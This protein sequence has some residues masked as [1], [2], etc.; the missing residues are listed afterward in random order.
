MR[1]LALALAGMLLTTGFAVAGGEGADERGE[2]GK[3]RDRGEAEE[4]GHG[5]HFA[6]HPDKWVLQNDDITVWFHQGERSKPVLKVF[7]STEDGN[8]SGFKLQLDELFEAR[9]V[10]PKA[11]DA[12]DTDD[13]GD[14][15]DG[16]EFRRVRGHRINLHPARE[17][18]TGVSNATDEVT[19]TMSHLFN[20]G[21]VTLVFHVPKNGSTVKF[22]VLVEDWKWADANNTLALRLKVLERGAEQEG[23]NATFSGGFVS[24]APSA[25]VTYPDGSTATIPVEG[26]VKNKGEGARVLLLFNGTGGY[27]KLDYDPTIGVQSGSMSLV[28]AAGPLA[29][30]AAVGA[31]AVALRRRR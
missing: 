1:W 30:M 12:D 29:A 31:A 9:R 22:D 21:N 3:G 4:H 27:T 14:D 2:R 6:K 8:K 5:K 26:V 17:W 19:V 16:P 23:D 25:Q 28:P 18:W 13:E 24:W 15:G 20:Q 11:G 10:A 7:R